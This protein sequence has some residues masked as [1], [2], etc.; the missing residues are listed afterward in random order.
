MWKLL[1]FIFGWDYVH[2]KNSADQGIARVFRD[3]SGRPVYWRY[4]ITKVL[5]VIEEENQVTWLTC[6]PSK[7]LPPVLV[8]DDRKE[9]SKLKL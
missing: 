2:W 4:K 7:Y 8:C 9:I 3:A 1:N 5:D 6:R